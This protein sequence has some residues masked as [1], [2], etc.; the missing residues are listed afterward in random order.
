[1]NVTLNLPPGMARL[2]FGARHGQVGV[3]AGLDN[4]DQRW[5]IFSTGAL[6]KIRLK[7]P[8][9]RKGTVLA[10]LTD[11]D[12]GGILEA[13]GVGGQLRQTAALCSDGLQ[14]RSLVAALRLLIDVVPGQA[15]AQADVT[16]R[17]PEPSISD[18]S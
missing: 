13:L 16:S 11:V 3:N 12:Q 9:S 6:T 15:V 14:K 8:I 10:G 1:M 5:S 7:G 18:A 17:R 2:A 4:H